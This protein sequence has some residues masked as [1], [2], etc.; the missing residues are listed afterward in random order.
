MIPLKL[1]I[2]FTLIITLLVLAELYISNLKVKSKND[3]KGQP[4]PM[5]KDLTKNEQADVEELV[6]VV[7]RVN[8]DEKTYSRKTVA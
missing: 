1:N 4:L 7:H 5:E 3:L 6:L 2:D 8:G